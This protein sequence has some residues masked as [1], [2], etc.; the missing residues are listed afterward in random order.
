VVSSVLQ[1]CDFAFSDLADVTSLHGGYAPLSGRFA[2]NRANPDGPVD[3]LV[4]A[5]L[6]ERSN[7]SPIAVASYACHPVVRGRSDGISADYPGQVCAQLAQRGMRPIYLNGLCGD[8]DPMPSIHC[9]GFAQAI[10]E[11]FDSALHPVPMTVVGERLKCTLRTPPITREEIHR[12]AEG[13]LSRA[14][15]FGAQKVAQIWE[16]EM[17]V[18]FEMLPSEERLS[19]ACLWLGGIPI[20]ALP[21]EGF[22]QTG[23]L[24]RARLGDPRAM[25]LGCAEELLGYLPTLDEIERKAYAALESS[26]LYKRLPPMAGEAERLGHLVG[27]MISETAR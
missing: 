18:A 22:T 15:S 9:M 3:P 5:F 19:I 23:E 27:R 2:Y 6:I 20:V 24:I 13:A 11:S 16:G 21:F 4:R 17:L 10:V 14:A 8:I 25:T 12:I 26:F 7:A 1:A